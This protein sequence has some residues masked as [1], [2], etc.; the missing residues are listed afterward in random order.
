MT[1]AKYNEIMSKVTVTP[2]M[3]ERVFSNIADHKNANEGKSRKKKGVIIRWSGILAAAAACLILVVSL[4]V[5]NKNIVPDQ[6]EDLAGVEGVIEFSTKKEL[7][8]KVGFKID[9]IDTLPFDAVSTDYIYSFGIARIEY[10]GASD[11]EI[12]F[13]VGKT[14]GED[15]SGDY[16]EY[17][18]VSE[19]KIGE[20]TVTIKGNDDTTSLATWTEGEYSYA[21]NAVL[22]VSDETMKE[23]IKSVQ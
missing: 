23:M 3:R 14:D 11:E 13:S 21:V 8:D 22:G 1:L 5:Y 20:S 15:V 16:N 17:S 10:H 18:N 19:E 4:N 12:T 7:E 9:E 6:Q 2:E